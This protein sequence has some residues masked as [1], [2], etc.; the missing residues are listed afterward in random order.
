MIK[1]PQASELPF[2]MLLA[3]GIGYG[4]GRIWEGNP[5]LLAL[6]MAVSTIADLILFKL[7]K[8]IGQVLNFSAEAVYSVTSLAASAT[9]VC[10][11]FRLNQV[12]QSMAGFYIFG[13]LAIFFAKLSILSK[14]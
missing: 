3:T 9:T 8:P 2:E 13:S 7:T 5:K 10:A 14:G 1:L 4:A 11:L 12:S 6:V